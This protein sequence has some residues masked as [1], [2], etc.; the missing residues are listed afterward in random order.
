VRK[1]YELRPELT[2]EF[3]K[4]T[5]MKMTAKDEKAHAEADV[6][7]ECKKAFGSCTNK[8]KVRHHDLKTGEYIGAF[9]ADCNLRMGIRSVD[10]PV[11]FHNGKGY[12][13]HFII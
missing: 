12:D 8:R 1:L 5:P 2:K 11:F 13:N 9:H 7:C 4:N 6:C 3:T 10:I